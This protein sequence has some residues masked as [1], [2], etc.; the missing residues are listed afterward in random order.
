MKNNIQNNSKQI[1][2][3]S[4][5]LKFFA[6]WLYQNKKEVKKKQWWMNNVQPCECGPRQGDQQRR[7]SSGWSPS[8][9]AIA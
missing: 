1:L 7:H 5:L 8:R 4:L 3:P 6:G 9:E 2:K